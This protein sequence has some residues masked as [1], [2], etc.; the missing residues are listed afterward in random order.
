MERRSRDARS[1]RPVQRSDQPHAGARPPA[2][3]DTS[4]IFPYPV[5]TSAR[6]E[7]TGRNAMTSA[8]LPNAHV[9]GGKAPSSL[10]FHTRALSPA[11]G[12]EL[13][14][15]DLSALMSDETFE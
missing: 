5:L 2:G 8:H 12:A 11:L 7:H 15:L 3:G 9:S 14:G 13:I 6:L 1:G 10:P 4:S